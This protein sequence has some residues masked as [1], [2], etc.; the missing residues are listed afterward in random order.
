MKTKKYLIRILAGI[1]VSASI[2]SSGT[3][4]QAATLS[5][6]HG[7]ILGLLPSTEPPG[8]GINTN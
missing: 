1:L 7:A 5:F 3:S 8:A 2:F 6:C 4:A